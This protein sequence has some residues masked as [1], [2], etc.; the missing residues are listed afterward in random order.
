MWRIRR[1]VV[2]LPGYVRAVA[3]W[4]FDKNVAEPAHELFSLLPVGGEVPD[5]D[6]ARCHKLSIGIEGVFRSEARAQYAGWPPESTTDGARVDLCVRMAINSL[7][8]TGVMWIDFAGAVFPF[9]AEID[10][11]ADGSTPVI[12]YIGQVDATGEPPRL[13]YG[14]LIV[15]VRDR[16]GRIPLAELVVGRR[17]TPIAWT[18]V[19][20]VH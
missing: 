8:V 19:L 4:W 17:Q 12:G 9:K 18:K 14:T 10:R 6:L 7:E 11:A 2:G 3:S 5:R 13:P 16:G 20:E 15:P 1:R